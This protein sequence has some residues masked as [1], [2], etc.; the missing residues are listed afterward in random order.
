MHKLS[1]RIFTSYP[2]PLYSFM[3]SKAILPSVT[4]LFSLSVVSNSYYNNFSQFSAVMI[5]V[6]HKYCNLTNNYLHVYNTAFG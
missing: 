2:Y 1:S 6:M 5:C 4:V 3:L